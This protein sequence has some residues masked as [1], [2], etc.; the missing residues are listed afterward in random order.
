[1]STDWW[2]VLLGAGCTYL[3]VLLGQ[4]RRSREVRNSS[5]KAQKYSCECGHSLSFH[6]EDTGKCFHSYYSGVFDKN[7][8][9]P[10]VRYV[11]ERPFSP[12]E[13]NKLIGGDQDGNRLADQ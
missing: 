8:K 1:M 5:S 6:S 12:D 7:M 13:L 11:G 9:C 4:W 2:T 3:G 10:C